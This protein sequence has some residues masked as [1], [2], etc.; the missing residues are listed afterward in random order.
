MK[1]RKICLALLGLV[2]S[3]LAAGCQEND[4]EEETVEETAEAAAETVDRTFHS[5]P[6]EQAGMT[7]EDIVVDLDSVEEPYHFVVLADLHIGC[8]SEDVTEKETVDQR[9]Q[10]FSSWREKT[11]E[12]NWKVM[13]DALNETGADG[14][15]L[16]GDMVDFASP[17]T[18]AS[19]KNGTDALRIPFMYIRAD[20]D[21]ENYFCDT[22]VR[23]ETDAIH[24]SIVPNASLFTFPEEDGEQGRYMKGQMEENGNAGVFSWEYDEFIIAGMNFTTSQ[25]SSEALEEFQKICDKGKPVILMTHV[26]FNSLVDDSLNRQSRKIWGDRNLTW[27]RDSYYFPDDNT[28][29]FLQLVYGENSPVKEVIAGHLHFKWNG[30]LTENVYQHVLSPAFEGYYSALTVY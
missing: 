15:L 27:G 8:Q 22:A 25:I 18:L 2:L 7:R 10:S 6:L 9:I 23:E 14:V 29:Q 12:E 4:A 17:A 1:K 30:F 11:P 3:V 16:A 5:W 21:V 26:P 24:A 13:V 20:H 28:G 19:L